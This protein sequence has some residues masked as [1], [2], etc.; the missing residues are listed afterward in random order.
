MYA[1]FND[2]NVGMMTYPWFA[3][4]SVMAANTV[5][6]GASFPE[7]KSVRYPTPGTTNPEVHL[8]IV[9]VTSNGNDTDFQQWNVKQPIALEGQ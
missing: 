2:T 9:N 5:G 6:G 4:G 1:T 7:T 8:W 3:S